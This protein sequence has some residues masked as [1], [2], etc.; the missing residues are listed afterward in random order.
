MARDWSAEF[1][2]EGRTTLEFT[3]TLDFGGPEGKRRV[4]VTHTWDSSG[5]T[6]R[7]LLGACLDAMR[8]GGYSPPDLEDLLDGPRLPT[9]IPDEFE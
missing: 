3:L 9:D 6:W 5:V 7:E 1:D 2:N 4:D 8:A